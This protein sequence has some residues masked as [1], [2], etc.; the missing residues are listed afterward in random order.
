MV[1]LTTI[2]LWSPVAEAVTIN[3]YKDG[4]PTTKPYWTSPMRQGSHGV[5][6]W[7]IHESLHKTY[8][9]FTVT[10][11]GISQRTGDPYAKATGING[12]RSMVVDLDETDPA[13]WAD[14][15]APALAAE[16]FIDEIHVKDFSWD[17]HGGWPADV[18]G[19]Y[20]ALTIGDTMLNNDG[21][22]PTGLNFLRHLGIT[23][24]QL[25][26]IY[27]YGSVDES[28]ADDQFNWGYDPVNYNVPEGSYATDAHHGEVRIRELKSA[29]K[30]LLEPR[31]TIAVHNAIL[32]LSDVGGW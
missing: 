2:K 1:G 31:R 29:I 7:S 4:E 6:E 32:L 22:T 18:R 14:D 30:S 26:P 20:L 15:H 12:G 21:V 16:Q 9:D 17:P 24:I 25:M 8:Y 10:I 13:D 19:K 23:H 11:D 27:D 3:F 5:W 28:H